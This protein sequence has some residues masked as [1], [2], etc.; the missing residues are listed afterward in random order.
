MKQKV[1][2]FTEQTPKNR[3]SPKIVRTVGYYRCAH[4]TVMAILIIFPVILQTV[5]NLN[6]RML[7]IGGQG[8]I[9]QRKE[10]DACCDGCISHLFAP[11][12]G[13]EVDVIKTKELQQLTEETLPTPLANLCC[14]S[15]Y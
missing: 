1:Y 11:R 12:T 14:H 4:V 8:M 13:V 6:L 3:P 15:L 5:I 7:A 10:N 9:L 2:T